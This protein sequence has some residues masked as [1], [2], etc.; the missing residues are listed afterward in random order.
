MKILRPVRQDNLPQVP[1]KWKWVWDDDRWA[2]RATD[3][4][5]EIGIT[6]AGDVTITTGRCPGLFL[7]PPETI[8]MVWL[9]NGG[10]L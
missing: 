8:D 3:G 9:V 5:L 2:L 7:L 4:S 1:S 6:L 10:Q